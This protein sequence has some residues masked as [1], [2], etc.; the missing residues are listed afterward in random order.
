[1]VARW[2]GTGGTGVKGGRIRKYKL[3]FIKSPRDV[4]YSIG[5]VVNN[6]AVTVYGLR[7]VLD[8]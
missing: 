8:L 5:N 3:A 6:I 2:E 7:W 4:K 1:M